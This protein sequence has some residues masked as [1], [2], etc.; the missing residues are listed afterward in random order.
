MQHLLIFLDKMEANIEVHTLG[1]Q[2]LK[3]TYFLV[4]LSYYAF[5]P[6]MTNNTTLQYHKE[7]K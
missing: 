2:D 7:R 1:L 5:K 3:F 4:Y 6:N